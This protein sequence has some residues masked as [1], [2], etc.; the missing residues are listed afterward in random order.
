MWHNL[1]RERILRNGNPRENSGLM[2]SSNLDYLERE[3][4]NTHFI[5]GLIAE[6]L[7]ALPHNCHARI[8]FKKT[9]LLSFH[10]HRG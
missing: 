6:L 10:G 8:E 5:Q 7:T 9:K 1:L 4:V 3:K 2:M